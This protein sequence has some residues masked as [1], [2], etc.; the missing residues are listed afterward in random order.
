M[1][2]LFKNKYC[3]MSIEDTN[4]LWLN[5]NAKTKDMTEKDFKEVLMENARLIGE[6]NASTN[7]VDIRQFHGS[8]GPE[9][10]EWRTKEL[11]PKYIEKGLKKQAFYKLKQ[12]P[13]MSSDGSK[14]GG[15]L[16]ESFSDE[17][18]LLKWLK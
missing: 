8:M 11:F 14:T 7:V 4:N 12:A 15:I 16:I 18:K 2:E 13:T 3:T 6:T 5:W 1:K 17:S 10:M 9:L